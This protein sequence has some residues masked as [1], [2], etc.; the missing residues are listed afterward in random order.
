MWLKTYQVKKT[1]IVTL[2]EGS[3]STPVVGRTPSTFDPLPLFLIE[4]REFLLSAFLDGEPKA[5]GS[6]QH[7]AA[8]SASPVALEI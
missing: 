4:G 8:A 5:K 3:G 7:R 1:K 2:Y 6:R